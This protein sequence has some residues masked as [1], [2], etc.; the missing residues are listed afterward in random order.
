MFVWKV[1]RASEAL[2]CEGDFSGYK[3][4]GMAKAR[5]RWWE[6]FGNAEEQWEDADSM[7]DSSTQMLDFGLSE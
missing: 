1:R 2:I 5:W 4:P 3:I 7:E 6:D